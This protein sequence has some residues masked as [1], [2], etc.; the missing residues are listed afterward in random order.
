[1]KLKGIIFDADGTLLDSMKFWDSIVYERL[2]SLGVTPD[3][4]L[5]QLLTPLSMKE[6]VEFIKDK[7]KLDISVDEI[8]EAENKIVE[9]FYLTDVK[10]KYGVLNL[11][12]SLQSLGIPM[13]VASATDRKLLELSLIHRSEPT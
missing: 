9:K 1:M 13:A 12:Q 11:L 6:S 7:F 8:I 4:N 5:I 3:D 10:L 2:Q